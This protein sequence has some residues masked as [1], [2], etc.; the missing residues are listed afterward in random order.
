M[1]LQ[2]EAGFPALKVIQHATGNNARIL[3][4]QDKTGSVRP[5]FA[6]DL[7]VVNGNPLENM[8][9]LSMSGVESVKGGEQVHT[10][11]VEWTIKDGYCYH[12]P[13][14]SAEVRAMVAKARQSHGNP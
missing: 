10:G 13:T 4:I 11:G 14:L 3:A 1:E 2:E 7:I 9:V 12:G 6:A 5:G 8:K